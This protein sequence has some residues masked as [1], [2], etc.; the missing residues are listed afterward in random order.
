M[1][2][3]RPKTLTAPKMWIGVMMMMIFD[4][5]RP[6]F[7]IS[8]D[9]RRGTYEDLRKN[10]LEKDN[11]YFDYVLRNLNFDDTSATRF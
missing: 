5:G 11:R 8:R 1:K 10:H 6:G 3:E 9:S 4:M 7:S 2:Q